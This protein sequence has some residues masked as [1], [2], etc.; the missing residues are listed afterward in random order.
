MKLATY[1][2]D[3]REAVG[4]IEG[5]MIFPLP[6][7]TDMLEL[8]TRYPQFPLPGA[9]LPLAGARLA[10]PIPHPRHDIICLGMNYLEHA[11]ETALFKG[12]PFAPPAHAVYF[13]KRV[14]RALGPE[15]AI[16]N[17]NHITKELDY[18]AELAIII[19]K[20]CARVSRE[21]VFDYIFGY[22]IVNDVTAREIQKAHEQ[23]Y[24]GKS[25][26]GFA[27]MGPWI[28]T[29]DEIADPGALKVESRVNGETRQKSDTGQMIF[30]IPHTISE[31]SQGITLEPGDIIITGT[32]SGVGMGFS[33]PRY[34]KS[35]DIME[36]EVEGIGVLHNTVE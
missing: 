24:F 35:G 29:A 7:R 1:Y 14:N 23:F 15:E 10:A 17:H 36:C 21:Q 25:L 13:S 26:D 22:T 5:D 3:G 31:L 18:E 11:R 2:Q 30:D 27:P 19:G 4:L 8:I 16:P 20:T 34:L 32:P 12:V 9:G 6:G 28:V 33:P